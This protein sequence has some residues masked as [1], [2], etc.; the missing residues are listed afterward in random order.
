M[1]TWLMWA[2]GIGT[3]LLPFLLALAFNGRHTAD[4]RG[5]RA[6]RRWRAG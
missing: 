1:D 3:L 5:R 6:A 4:S 2:L